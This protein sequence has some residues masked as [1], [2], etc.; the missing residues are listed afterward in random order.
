MSR[1]QITTEF[2]DYLAAF[3]SQGQVGQLPSLHEI[4]KSLGISV[5]RLREQLEVAKALGLVEA[6]P[7]IGLRRLPY[8]FSPAVRQSLSYAIQINP[9]NFAIYS[10]LRDQIEMVYW[11]EAVK[12]LT[13]QD[14]E[15]LKELVNSAWDKLR[16]ERVQIP[17]EEHKQLHLL[18]Y[19]R[20]NNPF[21]LGL[22]EAYWEAYEK[23]G[24]SIYS[25]YEY[26]QKV[27]ELHQSMVEAIC[28]GDY[29]LGYQ[30]LI[31]H[32]N[33]LPHQTSPGSN[34]DSNPAST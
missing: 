10:D 4:S 9:Q 11:E 15:E 29:G 23:I 25:D 13:P 31:G 1:T 6:K 28:A 24:L 19:K 3:K 27:W 12:L 26:L 5:A 17:H 18:I 21:V 14:Q 16:G 20:L 22:L 8:S 7:R 33:L 30:A 32:R 34:G 2:I